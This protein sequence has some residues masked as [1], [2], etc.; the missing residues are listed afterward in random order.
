[1]IRYI[2]ECPGNR[3]LHKESDRSE[4]IAC[5]CRK[6]KA[7][8]NRR[9]IRV[10]GALRAVIAEGDEEMHPHAPAR[11]LRRQRVRSILGLRSN[12]QI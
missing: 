2:A 7:A 5:E 9:G 12:L 1:M 10:K 11:E 8:H 3:N 6:A 4:R